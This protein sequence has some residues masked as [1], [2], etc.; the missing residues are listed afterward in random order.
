MWH[1]TVVHCAR[2][3]KWASGIVGNV[4][5]D[6]ISFQWGV[7]R[8]VPPFDTTSPLVQWTT[9]SYR[10]FQVNLTGCFCHFQHPKYFSISLSFLPP[11][12]NFLRLLN[13]KFHWLWLSA[14]IF[15][16]KSCYLRC[17]KFGKKWLSP[18][19]FKVSP[20]NSIEMSKNETLDSLTKVTVQKHLKFHE[21]NQNMKSIGVFL[22]G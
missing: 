22:H 14:S 5:S 9:G 7:S 12:R 17:P 6:A 1:N 8:F 4:Q 18:A 13:S 3:K 15:R 21:E 2:P 10:P 16:A 11:M 20:Y 19:N